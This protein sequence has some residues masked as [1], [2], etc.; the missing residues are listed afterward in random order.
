[1][2]DANRPSNIKDENN[3]IKVEHQYHTLDSTDLNS[4]DDKDYK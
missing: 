1:L 2:I 3:N 4:G